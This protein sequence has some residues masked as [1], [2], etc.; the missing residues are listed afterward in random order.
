MPNPVSTLSSSS[1]S[2]LPPANPAS[3]LFYPFAHPASSCSAAIS[4]Q[5][6]E[7]ELQKR[8][9]LG[10]KVRQQMEK[11]MQMRKKKC[12]Q[13]QRRKMCYLCKPFSYT[14]ALNHLARN[15]INETKFIKMNCCI[16]GC[17]NNFKPS[18]IELR[19]VNGQTR[20]NS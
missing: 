9:R 14:R 13:E 18:N 19:N 6:H 11:K 20:I 17:N 12:M 8:K 2:S 10:K 5:Q 15:Y 4:D 16:D 3:F 1:S 7:K